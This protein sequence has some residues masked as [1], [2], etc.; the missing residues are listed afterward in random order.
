VFSHSTPPHSR[1]PSNVSERETISQPYPSRSHLPPI[2]NPKPVDPP[3]FGDHTPDRIAYQPS[4]PAT[5][6]RTPSLMLPP[7]SSLG[8][9]S[10]PAM[11]ESA[12]RK[13][14]F[15]PIETSLTKRSHDDSFGHGEHLAHKSIRSENE[16]AVHAGKRDSLEAAPRWEGS[17]MEYRRANGTMTTKV[18]LE[19]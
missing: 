12:Q 10:S 8:Q 4:Q 16:H 6:P 18:R 19:V 9:F 17:S 13:P 5:R 3:A 15:Y 11:H 14:P 7:I 1:N 2:L